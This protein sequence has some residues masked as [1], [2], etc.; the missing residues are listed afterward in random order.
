MN[1][2]TTTQIAAGVRQIVLIVGGYAIGKG[3]L[4]ADTVEMLGAVA[5]VVVPLVWGQIST[6]RL[7]Q[8]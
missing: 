2:V 4:A 1:D 3:W 7:A 8:K 5:L 6:R